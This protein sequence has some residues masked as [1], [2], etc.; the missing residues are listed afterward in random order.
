MRLFE[1]VGVALVRQRNDAPS[2]SRILVTVL[3]GA[4]TTSTSPISLAPSS[5]TNSHEKPRRP[6]SFSLFTNVWAGTEVSAT[7]SLSG[8]SSS[9]WKLDI[10]LARDGDPGSQPPFTTLTRPTQGSPCSSWLPPNPKE[11]CTDHRD[12]TDPVDPRFG[13]EN[14]LEFEGPPSSA[15]L[16]VMV[17]ALCWSPEGP[18]ST[19]DTDGPKLSEETHELLHRHCEATTGA[20][21]CKKT[22]QVMW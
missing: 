2:F 5:P 6:R 12:A 21:K 18:G 15:P 17:A 16:R 8:G 1:C 10:R 9:R 14:Q 22:S 11:L 3:I 13:Q 7:S 4:C 19:F 20:L